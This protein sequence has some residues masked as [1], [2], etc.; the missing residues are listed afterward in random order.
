M[1]NIATGIAVADTGELVKTYDKQKAAYLGN[2]GP[3]YEQ[4]I[5]DLKQLKRMLM[6]HSREIK[7]AINTD[8]GCRSNIESNL[9]DIGSSAA[10][11]RDISRNLKKWMRPQKRRA[12]AI[13]MGAKARVIPQPLGIVGVIVPWNF[14]V[15]LSIPPIATAFAAGNRC[16]VK[17]SENSRNLARVLMDISPKYFPEEKLA[18]FDETGGVGIEFSKLPFDLMMFTG[19]PNTAKAVMASAAQNLTPVILEL[20]GKNPVIV[21]PDYPL[22]KAVERIVCAKQANAGQICLNVDYVF[23]HESQVEEFVRLMKSSTKRMIPDI[24]SQYFTAIIDDKSVNRLEGMLKD[25]HEKGA[26]V[27]NLSDQEVNREDKKFPFHLVLD[28]TPDMQISQ[29]E[30]FGPITT[31]RTYKTPK[32]VI[33]YV[34]AGE[35][36]LGFYV[37]SKNKQ[38]T[39]KYISETMSGGVTVNDVGLHAAPNDLPFG[40]VGHSGMGHYHGYDGFT[41]FSKMRPVLYQAKYSVV[42]ML[43]PPYKGW[44]K[45]ML[46]K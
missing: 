3:S 31:V 38:L 35:R 45:N 41:S 44:I 32:E 7:E 33:D 25:A 40:G 20:G 27:I 5:D 37:F 19:S 26:R 30:T 43:A 10:I 18:F 14:P 23:L 15:Y 42:N 11:I 22:D 12:G 17:M 21:D 1:N 8:Y 6:K 34:N 4:R 39:G 46:D 9:A 29:R 28:P 13:F 16:M 24:N 2:P 36:P